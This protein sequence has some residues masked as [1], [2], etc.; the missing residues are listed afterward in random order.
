MNEIEIKENHTKEFT[1]KF[2][3][4]VYIDFW[5]D[6]NTGECLIQLYNDDDE[7]CVTASGHASEMRKLADAM[8]KC[9]T[10]N[11]GDDN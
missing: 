8:N 3:D 6:Q 5:S 10:D 4:S 9:L 7:V 2:S 11:K 1:L